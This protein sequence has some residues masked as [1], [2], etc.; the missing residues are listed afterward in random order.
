MTKEYRECVR[1]KDQ[2]SQGQV[3]TSPL[4]LPSH[5]SLLL[6]CQKHRVAQ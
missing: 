2:R 4:P 6:H 1:H 3:G 5:R